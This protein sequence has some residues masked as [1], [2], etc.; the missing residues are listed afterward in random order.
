LD[1]LSAAALLLL[2]RSFSLLDFG[3]LKG[4]R[5]EEDGRFGSSLPHSASSDVGRPSQ[6]QLLSLIS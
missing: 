2:K 6:I 1:R 3:A 5:P 4:C